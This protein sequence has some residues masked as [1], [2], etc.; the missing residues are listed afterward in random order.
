M[1]VPSSE[2]AKAGGASTAGAKAAAPVAAAGGAAPA[3]GAEDLLGVDPK[4]IELVMA[5]V[6]CTRAQAAQALKKS[7]GDIVNA[8]MELVRF[9]PIHCF[10]VAVHFTNASSTQ[11]F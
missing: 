3:G 6:N 5:Q 2:P 10:C 7:N 1:E 9:K 4:D 8:I 11:Q